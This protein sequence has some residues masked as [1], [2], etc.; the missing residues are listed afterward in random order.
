MQKIVCRKAGKKDFEAICQ[1]RHQLLND[2]EERLALEYAPYDEKNDREWVEYCLRCKQRMVVLV[3][4]DQ[5]GICAHSIVCVEKVSPKM[6]AY[7]TYKKKARLVHLYVAINRRHQGIGTALMQYTFK[8]LKQK[9]VEFI[10]LECYVGNDK[11]S[12]LYDKVGFKDV[13]VEKRYTFS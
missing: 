11:A 13:F 10:D 8:Y 6:Q 9:G 12:A 3:A 4:E 7:V 5:D 2:P 1:L